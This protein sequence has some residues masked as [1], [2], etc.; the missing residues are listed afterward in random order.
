MSGLVVNTNL[1]ALQANYSLNNTTSALQSSLL[2]LSTG[3]KINSAAD[4][5]SGLAISQ[6]MTAQINGLNAAT[7]N[8][9]DG[10]SVLQTADGGLNTSQTILQRINTLAVSAANDGTLTTTDKNL[11]Q[12]EVNQLTAELDRMASTVSFNGK[13]LLDGSYTGQTLQVGEG[14]GSQ[15]QLTVN[16]GGISSSALGLSG[17]DI[18]NSASA[19]IATVGSAIDQV[20]AT[21]GNIG[22]T[23]NRLNY[24]VQNLGI[25]VQNA[26]ASVSNIQDVNMATE[27]SN[28][29]RLQVLQQSGTAMLAQAN[30]AP[31]A[32]MKLLP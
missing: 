17:L 21:R 1:S 23:I 32:V 25:E 24:A 20:S 14:S 30:Q 29:T 16:V 31:Q 12:S 26:T 7:Q 11:M 22:A 6:S 10:V 8:A 3:M 5:A 19:A 27:M 28:F 2:K 4:D 9:Q 15:Y 18:V 13:S